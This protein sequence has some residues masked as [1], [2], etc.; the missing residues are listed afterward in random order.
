MNNRLN[1]RVGLVVAVAATMAL[2]LP[3]LAGGRPLHAE[4]SSANEVAPVAGDPGTM[5]TAHVTLNQGQ[6]EVCFHVEVEGNHAPIVAAHIHAGN[7]ATNG[8]VVVDFRWAETGGHGCSPASAELIK[9]I[10]QNP[11][12]YYINV[13]NS[14]SPPGAARGQLSK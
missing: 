10:R 7:A 8:P 5:G 13:H 4:L 14:I 3:A 11:W 12:N 6:G 1:R 9:D 2:A